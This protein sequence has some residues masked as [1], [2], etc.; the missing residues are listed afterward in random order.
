MCVLLS[1]VVQRM[2]LASSAA[3]RITDSS[4]KTSRKYHSSIDQ[5][6]LLKWRYM[7]SG[8][9]HCRPGLQ[10]DD[11][12]PSPSFILYSWAFRDMTKQNSPALT[13]PIIQ[14]GVADCGLNTSKWNKKH[15]CNWDRDITGQ[16]ETRGF[17]LSRPDTAENLLLGHNGG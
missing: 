2:I 15:I 1:R 17:Y 6:N 10:R 16:T 14:R 12:A 7:C 5:L 4:G 11:L 13:S 9:C 3:A 8:I